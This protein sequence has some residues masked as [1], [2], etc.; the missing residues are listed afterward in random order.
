MMQSYA[1]SN[2]VSPAVGNAKEAVR[3]KSKCSE[4]NDFPNNRSDRIT[5]SYEAEHPRRAKEKMSWVWKHGGF[6]QRTLG[7]NLATTSK[8]TS[9]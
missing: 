4:F 3:Q 2:F 9:F 7:G 5:C 6:H 8:F 1:G